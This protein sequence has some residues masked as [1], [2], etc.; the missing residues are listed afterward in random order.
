M[1]EN[2]KIGWTDHTFNPWWGCEKVS[3]GCLNCYA[4]TFA[5]R[6]HPDKELWKPGSPRLLMKDSYWN[7]PRKW[8]TKA[9]KQGIRPFVFCGS[10]CDICDPQAPD[11]VIERLFDLIRETPNLF[12][13]LLTKRPER[14]SKILP[15]DWGEGWD[16]VMLMTTC[17]NQARV[18]ERIPILLHA[19]CRYRGISIEPMLGPIDFDVDMG[20]EVNRVRLNCGEPHC[21]CGLP[22]I[23]WVIVGGESG[24]GARPMHPDWVR[25]IRDQCAETETPFFFKQWGEWAVADQSECGESVFPEYYKV[26]PWAEELKFYRYGKNLSGDLLDGKQYH[27]FP[28]NGIP[29]TVEELEEIERESDLQWDFTSSKKQGML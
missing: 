8:N 23:D 14:F 20:E 26:V 9:E 7:Q 28:W 1:A 4:E 6:C 2:S 19:P 3:E 17:E 13:L 25:S 16:N 21:N 24:P 15:L 18:D 29:R 22:K 5:N 12:W 27:E 11:G 10:M